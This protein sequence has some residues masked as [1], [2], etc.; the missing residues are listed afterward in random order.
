MREIVSM[1]LAGRVK[2]VVGRVVGFGD[3]PSALDSM[4][5]RESV[6]RTIATLD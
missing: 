3:I 5:N 1:V 6:G 4:A 2:P